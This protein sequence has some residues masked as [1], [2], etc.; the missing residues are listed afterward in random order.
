MLICDVAHNP[1]AVDVLASAIDGIPHA[2]L[3]LV[4][5]VMKD[6]EYRGMIERLVPLH[7]EFYAVQA[8]IARSLSAGDMAEA[9]AD[10]GGAVSQYATITA[11]LRA[12][13]RAAGENDLIVVTGSH[14]V[15][16][17]AM[18]VLKRARRNKI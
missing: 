11:A 2:K 9:I 12:A 10:A 14:Y 5:G 4:M 6:K 17:E 3:H 8:S 13:R 16:G 18:A 7:P 1:A 15:V